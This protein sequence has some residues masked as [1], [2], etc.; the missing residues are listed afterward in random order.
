MKLRVFS[1][2]V[3]LEAGQ[4]LALDDALGAKVQPSSARLWITEEGD[5]TDFVVD[6]GQ[7]YEI[8]HDG[9]TLVQALEPTW[10]T[11]AEAPHCAANRAY[12]PAAGARNIASP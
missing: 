11:F 3:S 4:V 9:R 2:V 8:T 10:V 5:Y 12:S 7:S 6:P 1:P